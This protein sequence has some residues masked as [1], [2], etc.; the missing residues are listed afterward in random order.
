MSCIYDHVKPT[1]REFNP[2]HII[3]H[4]ET[5]EVKRSKRASQI[6]RSLCHCPCTATKVTNDI[7]NCSAKGQSK[8]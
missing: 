8:L 1:I 2:N 5:N 3:F 4:I 6:S 7:A